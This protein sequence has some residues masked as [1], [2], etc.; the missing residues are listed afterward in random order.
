[1]A[2]CAV[3]AVPDPKWGEAIRAAV[4]LRPGAAAT[5]DELIAFC[6]ERLARFKV[7]KA[8]DVMAELPETAVGKILRRALREPYWKG[9][10]R[11][12]HGAE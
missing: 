10:E 8:I 7:P 9:R 2:E 6:K 12:V 5:S 3:F 11:A 4:T 1:V